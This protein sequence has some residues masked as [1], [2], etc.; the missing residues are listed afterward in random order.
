[1]GGSLLQLTAKGVED[2][3]LTGNANIT[4]FKIVYRRHMNF[5]ICDQMAIS[6]TGGNFKSKNIFKMER[7]GDLLHTVYIMYD[8]PDIYIKK[9]KPTFKNIQNILKS[10]GIEWNYSPNLGT[11]LV[12][13]DIYNSSDDIGIVNTVNEKINH[14]VNDYNFSLN[15]KII[16]DDPN[17]F[18]NEI[19]NLIQYISDPD[20]TDIE[21]D[22]I[23]I[24]IINDISSEKLY[25]I[26]YIS[27]ILG[28]YSSQYTSSSELVD[29]PVD[30]TEL[31]SIFTDDTESN[32][33]TI[34]LYND[35]CHETIRLNSILIDFMVSYSIDSKIY[36]TG[37]DI[38]I[39]STYDDSNYECTPLHNNVLY[40]PESKEK[41]DVHQMR[42]YTYDDFIV[43]FYISFLYN[44]LRLRIYNNLNDYTPTTNFPSFNK[45]HHFDVGTSYETSSPLDAESETEIY[46]ETCKISD[47]DVFIDDSLIFYHVF[48]TNANIRKVYSHDIG[49]NVENYFN[50]EI[51]KVYYNFTKYEN[52]LNVTL[53]DYK[54][55]DSYKIFKKYMDYLNDNNDV[56]SK[57]TSINQAIFLTDVIKNNID[58]NMKQ[59]FHQISNIM[60]TLINSSESND[61]SFMITF[62]KTF[63]YND[64]N[65][66][67]TSPVSSLQSLINSE[68]L[69]LSDN[70]SSILFNVFSF[71]VKDDETK[72]FFNDEIKKEV[73]YFISSCENKLNEENYEDY[74]ND[75]EL[76]T[77]L[78]FRDGTNERETLTDVLNY[79]TEEETIYSNIFNN[80]SVMNNIPFLVVKDVPKL[81][82]DTLSK[83]M[84][85]I[86]KKFY[87]KPEDIPDA[88]IAK[89]L[90]A[91]DFRDLN[92][93]REFDDVYIEGDIENGSY[94]YEQVVLPI[95][96]F[97]YDKTING[98]I[99]NH[100]T[101]DN[102]ISFINDT[103]YETLSNNYAINSNN[104]LCCS[105]R[106]NKY[107]K[108]ET[109]FWQNRESVTSPVDFDHWEF[110]MSYGD[111]ENYISVEWVTNTYTRMFQSICDHFFDDATYYIKNSDLRR[112]LNYLI[113][114]IVKSFVF[115]YIPKYSDYSDNGYKILG[116]GDIDIIN[117]TFVNKG[118]VFINSYYQLEFNDHD[119]SKKYCDAISSI[120]F[121]TEYKFMLLYN[122]LYNKVFLS[123]TYYKNFLGNQ[124]E[125]MCK[126]VKQQIVADNT[127]YDSP[128][129]YEY[130]GG[131][132]SNTRDITTV[133]DVTYGGFNFIQIRNWGD[134]KTP[135]D[136]AHDIFSFLNDNLIFYKY[137]LARYEGYKNLLDVK[138]QTSGLTFGNTNPG[139]PN[140]SD[141][142]DIITTNGSNR[143]P[144]N[145]VGY[146]H[147]PKS[148]Y[149]YNSCEYI[150]GLI[151]IHCVS[152]YRTYDYDE[153]RWTDSTMRKN[154]VLYFWNYW[155]SGETKIYGV[156]DG[157]YNTDI[158]GNLSETVEK[159]NISD[160]TV[161]IEKENNPFTS[162]SLRQ[163]YNNLCDK[164][165]YTYEILKTTYETYLKPLLYDES[166]NEIITSLLFNDIKN[167]NHLYNDEN[168]NIFGNISTLAW[169]LSDEIFS[170]LTDGNRTTKIFNYLNFSHLTNL[171]A[172]KSIDDEQFNNTIEKNTYYFNEKIDMIKKKY[173][174]I[175][176]FKNNNVELE[177]NK[178]DQFI[179]INNKRKNITTIDSVDLYWGNIL[180]EDIYFLENTDINYDID[181]DINNGYTL[182]LDPTLQ[183]VNVPLEETLLN[184]IISK[185]P[186]FAWVKELGYKLTKKAQIFIGG[187]PFGC[188]F[189]PQLLHMINK[190]NPNKNQERGH[191]KMI[192]ND[193]E[194]YTISS[195]KRGMRTLYVELPWWFCIREGNSLP[196]TNMMYSEVTINVEVNDLDSVLYT[197]ASSYFHKTPKLKTKISCQYI[198][199][200]EDDRINMAKEKIEYLMENYNYNGRHTVSA[201]TLSNDGMNFVSDH[202]DYEQ[203]NEINLTY[204]LAL[205][206]SNPVKYF[207]WCVKFRDKTTELPEDKIDWNEHGYNVRDI[208]GNK[209]KISK[210]IDSIEIK[211][212]GVTRESKKDE[213]YYT[214]VVPYSKMCGSLSNGEYMYSFALFPLAQQPSGSANYTE[215][216]DSEMMIK[217]MEDIFNKNNPNL[218]AE[219]DLWSVEYNVMR[220][221][222]GFAAQAFFK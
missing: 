98:T 103:Y 142:D 221:F 168:E 136:M 200:D 187:Q 62:F 177:I 206:L 90:K 39:I 113:E 67:Y 169:Y 26:K 66:K 57:I 117:G 160:T 184:M 93:G 100:N 45:V 180:N 131:T 188:A 30:S 104:V 23:K 70:F 21:M 210:I 101:T 201:N 183:I 174:A 214:H 88:I 69:G 40:R 149:M 132:H 79:I 186:N 73:G 96:M 212:N 165:I 150:S 81:M 133:V 127:F 52:E 27:N 134:N 20:A 189:T 109:S 47:H 211:M 25:F 58:F 14:L 68:I 5:S 84:D 128:H 36:S 157:I 175:F 6:K 190:L 85:V 49:K 148:K 216:T 220:V 119:V 22:E 71:G 164:N 3:Y 43:I 86:I 205:K 152:M 46:N 198:Y 138:N 116:L 192:G 155:A 172:K 204:P 9:Q 83:Y 11:D 29:L 107:F 196:L 137:T 159:I 12:T 170:K 80:N 4:L 106:P 194:M 16:G 19:S 1:M 17:R 120:W 64:I 44:S 54:I 108:K 122:N 15:A 50:D 167:I 154:H 203:K 144:T 37:T 97:I 115:E 114:A 51:E 31:L 105:L 153:T 65:K 207:F 163:W 74:I 173:L 121:L 61:D 33:K 209:E 145:V 94:Y 140:F 72:N 2:L 185:S 102:T 197:D 141:Y 126:F 181:P 75:Y 208:Y 151:C 77:R 161:L 135:G 78:Q 182:R 176:P 202:H 178:Y 158:A 59:N 63:E 10:I 213:A 124:M 123:E 60:T 125:T 99:I 218:T 111:V 129:S 89:F 195:L 219:I 18:N 87:E 215:I 217:F 32:T 56:N 24:K 179:N 35:V 8:I 162:Y 34:N 118:T 156:L 7:N 91:M 166:D 48:D 76:W 139:L 222:S 130:H 112:E 95:K 199:L 38:G 53:N 146:I 55:T 110:D 28:K 193:K 41:N 147:V 191:N 42:F 171:I 143:T 13:I 82:Y 92:D